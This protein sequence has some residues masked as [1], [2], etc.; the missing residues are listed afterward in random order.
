MKEHADSG[1]DNSE[2][3]DDDRYK[4]SGLSK[5]DKMKLLEIAKKNALNVHGGLNKNESIAMR[6]GGL[7]IEQLTEKAKRIQDGIADPVSEDVPDDMLNHP[8]EVVEKA[9]EQLTFRPIFLKPKQVDPLALPADASMAALTKSFP[10]SAG[11]QHRE[12]IND[13]DMEKDG[14]GEWTDGATGPAEDEN[15]ES[16]ES[17]KNE[18]KMTM[19]DMQVRIKLKKEQ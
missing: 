7:T 19:A 1:S 14:V 18:P 17:E 15:G 5:E 11:I 16:E 6:A 13:Y 10:V 12:V 4:G 8:F 2:G 9:P 3:E